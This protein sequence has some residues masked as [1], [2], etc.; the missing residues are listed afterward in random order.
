[1][2]WSLGEAP[3]SCRSFECGPRLDRAKQMAKQA[4]TKVLGSSFA[5]CRIVLV[6]AVTV[7]QLSHKDNR[8]HWFGGGQARPT[9]T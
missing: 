9:L 7:W 5:S 1:M 4:E 8:R 2:R 3:P 6:L